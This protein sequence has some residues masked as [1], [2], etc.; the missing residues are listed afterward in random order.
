MNTEF[1][2]IPLADLDLLF[3]EASKYNNIKAVDIDSLKKESA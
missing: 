1:R 3:K 2:R